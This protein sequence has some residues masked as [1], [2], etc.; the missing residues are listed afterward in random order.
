MKITI[1]AGFLLPVPPVRGGAMEKTWHRLAREFATAGHQVTFVSRSWPGWAGSETIDGVHHIRRRGADHTRFLALNLVLDFIWGLRVTRA[2][3]P[4]DVV[5]TNTVALPVWLRLLKPAAGRVA[6][7]IA[8]MPNGQTKLYGH[9]D[10]LYSLSAAVTARIVSENPSLASRIVAF[11]MPIDWSLH[12]ASPHTGGAPITIGYIGRLHPEK[13]I[14]LIL[15]AAACLAIRTDLPPWR[16]VLLG[17]IAVPSGGGGELWLDELRAR[18]A[19]AL[20][21]RLIV[22]SPEFD[23]VKLADH[24]RSLDVFCYPSLAEKG[25]TFGVA[26]AEAMAAGCAPIVSGLSCFN[27][28]VI[29]GKTGLVF[30]HTSADAKTKLAASLGRLLQDTALRAKLASNAR[31]HSRQHDF[32]VVAASVLGQLTRLV[33][34]ESRP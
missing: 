26:I 32:P 25:E 16:L 33:S 8:R 15:A 4:S 2:L 11:P 10:L 12:S 20:G 19:I 31:N 28:L 7:V 27:E 13:G 6:A 22:L 3:P 24:Y 23:P 1:V 17:P 30:D 9:V 29:D 34:G 5:I 14:A 18:H 21:D